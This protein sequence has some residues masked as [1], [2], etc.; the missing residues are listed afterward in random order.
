MTNQKDKEADTKEIN[1]CVCGKKE[2]SSEWWDIKGKDI[3]NDCVLYVVDVY[4]DWECYA[5]TFEI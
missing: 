2:T 3:C 4:T 1:C 5:K